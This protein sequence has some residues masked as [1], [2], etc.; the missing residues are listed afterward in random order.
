MVLSGGLSEGGLLSWWVPG[1]GGLRG[2]YVV[3][4]LGQKREK[5]KI[6]KSLVEYSC[7]CEWRSM[8]C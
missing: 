1:F 5:K 4:V 8:W 2:S 3:A 6:V 7:V